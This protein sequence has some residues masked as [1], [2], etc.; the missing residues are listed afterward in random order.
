MRG[1]LTREKSGDA[2][3]RDKCIDLA[4]CGAD[5]LMGV[6]VL[7]TWSRLITVPTIVTRP[8]KPCAAGSPFR[9][10]RICDEL[11]AEPTPRIRYICC[12]C[13]ANRPELLQRYGQ[14][15][16]AVNKKSRFCSQNFSINHDLSVQPRRFAVW[17]W[18][19][20]AY[21]AGWSVTCQECRTGQLSGGRQ[22]RAACLAEFQQMSLEK[23]AWQP[24]T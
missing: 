7:D 16:R 1:V 15:P 2:L 11:K 19:S 18:S 24:Q 6:I 12:V 20:L 13:E 17:I 23:A 3:R 14:S 5:A 21:P 22:P 4:R 9:R 10:R 8:R